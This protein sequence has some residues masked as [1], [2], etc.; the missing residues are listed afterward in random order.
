MRLN[1][2]QA[3]YGVILL[4]IASSA[5]PSEFLCESLP[6]SHNVDHVSARRAI[7]FLKQKKI[8]SAKKLSAAL[9]HITKKQVR[10]W[11]DVANYFRHSELGI[12]CAELIYRMI[13]RHIS[14]AHEKSYAHIGLSKCSGRRGDFKQSLYHAR[15]ARSIA[16]T[17]GYSWLRLGDVI[18]QPKK[19]HAAYTQALA[20]AEQSGD[21]YLAAITYLGI[22]NIYF[23]AQ[24]FS[25]QKKYLALYR[26][27]YDEY[28][29]TQRHH[30][31]ALH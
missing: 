6:A 7:K 12:P 26:E 15:K 28:Q 25:T 10:S 13:V 31:C 23:R 5:W 14:S 24:N 21:L 30:R 20:R 9:A 22:S 11:F 18:Q 27:K 3:F 29:Q 2:F 19:R 8:T 4:S 17:N 16:P 1:Y